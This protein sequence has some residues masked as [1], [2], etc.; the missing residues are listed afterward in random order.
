MSPSHPKDFSGPTNTAG[1]PAPPT[2]P[3][4]P[5]PPIVENASNST[6]PPTAKPL[7]VPLEGPPG[8]FL[9]ELLIFNGSPFKDHWAYFVRSHRNHNVGVYIHATGDVLNGFNFEIKRNHDLED[10]ENTPTT[11]I[12]L[13]WVAAEH[14]DEDIM[15]NHGEYKVDSVPV[16]SFEASA[17]K[18]KPPGKTLNSAEDKTRS[19]RKVSQKNCQSWL[20]EAADY[21]VQDGMFSPKVAVYLQAIKQ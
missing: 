21:L 14:F 19:G 18:A 2:P 12:P 11:R 3:G 4:L 13:Q 15:L 17:H 7:T 6:P 16:C 5:P 9:V 1:P 10:P 8:A 20:V